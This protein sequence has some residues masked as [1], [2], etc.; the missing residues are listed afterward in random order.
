LKSLLDLG[1]RKIGFV[2]EVIVGLDVGV[3]AGIDGHREEEIGNT[4]AVI[5]VGIAGGGGRGSLGVRAGRQEEA[6]R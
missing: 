4:L 6:E 1:G 3:A 2:D 5:V